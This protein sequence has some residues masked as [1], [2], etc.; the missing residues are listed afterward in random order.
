MIALNR[1]STIVSVLK[2]VTK[3][4]TGDPLKGNFSLYVCVY[5]SLDL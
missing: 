4:V 5:V 1:Q 3:N 2:T